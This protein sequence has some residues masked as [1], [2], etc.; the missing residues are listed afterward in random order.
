M[1]INFNQKFHAEAIRI[2][3]G[4][5]YDDAIIGKTKGGFL[6]YSYFRLIQVHMRYMNESEENSKEWI[7]IECLGLTCESFPKFEV[8]Y[9]RKYIWKEY[10]PSCLKRLRKRK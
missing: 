8:S 2:E 3:P 6:L 10:K 7:D 4:E 5:W 1:K 9:S